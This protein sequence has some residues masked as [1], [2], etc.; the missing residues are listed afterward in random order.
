MAH[1]QASQL[2]VA[3][4]RVSTS[5][6]SSCP[7]IVRLPQEL[8]DAIVDIL[9]SE[10][11]RQALCQCLLVS[12]A[13]YGRS[14]RR[15]F[16]KI[17]MSELTPKDATKLQDL[18][19][20]LQN[21]CLRGIV[22]LSL[23]ICS[24]DLFMLP[25]YNTSFRHKLPWLTQLDVFP[26]VLAMLSNLNTF[27]LHF[28]TNGNWLLINKAIRNGFIKV[29]HS[30]SLTSLSLACIINFP[31]DLFEQFQNLRSLCLFSVHFT[32]PGAALTTGHTS[33]TTA[34]R[35]WYL[36][37]L[38]DLENLD[39][40][41]SNLFIKSG[42][43]SK[44]LF[45]RLKS[46][47]LSDYD[48]DIFPRDYAIP[49]ME[50]FTLYDLIGYIDTTDDD[51]S[52]LEVHCLHRYTALQQLTLGFRFSPKKP[53][54]GVLVQLSS[55]A[56]PTTIRILELKFETWE[57]MTRRSEE[58]FF[59]DCNTTWDHVDNFL[60]A[61][62]AFPSLNKVVLLFHW[63]YHKGENDGDAPLARLRAYLERV[64]PKLTG[65]QKIA[66]EVEYTEV[67]GKLFASD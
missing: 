32:F 64:L 52:S 65:S 51:V 41:H 39:C 26:S 22:P 11:C 66:L 38:L 15:L 54:T 23:S 44:G 3:K 57:S 31:A 12:R 20:I 7:N 25:E 14:R 61:S 58:Q 10:G 21:D 43:S 30:S 6:S 16:E 59:P 18:L 67:L 48:S 27:K 60:T 29:L 62:K 40:K 45:S 49:S 9:A 35:T 47:T 33:G 19:Q 13:F 37:G 56:E 24:L 50:S 2:M 28:A 8:I 46:L 34:D 1:I 42:H 4:D 63:R 36:R 5:T 55:I 53:P 17:S